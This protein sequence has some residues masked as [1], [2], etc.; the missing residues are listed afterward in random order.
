M[1][2]PTCAH[3]ATSSAPPRTARTL[4][5]ALRP[6]RPTAMI[7]RARPRLLIQRT[8]DF[9]Q[10]RAAGGDRILADLLFFLGHHEIHAVQRFCGDV[11]VEIGL[12]VSYQPERSALMRIFV[13]ALREPDLRRGALHDRQKTPMELIARG[14]T[15]VIG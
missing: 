11:L 15:E 1:M 14:A 4:S 10:D 12:V 13:V 9:A 2:E 3:S 7:A 6:A 5:S 8:E